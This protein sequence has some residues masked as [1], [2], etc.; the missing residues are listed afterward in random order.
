MKERTVAIVIRCLNEAQHIGKLLDGVMRQTITDVEIIVVDSGSTDTTLKIAA[1]Y[2]TKIVHLRPEEFT[3]G[4]ALNVGCREASAEFL[5]FASAHVHPVSDRWLEELLLPLEDERVAL[6]YGKQRGGPTTK[7]SEHRVFEQCFPGHSAARQDPSFC[8][9]AN[10]AIRRALWERYPYD[11]DLT[12]LEDLDWATRVRKSGFEVSYA[13]AAEVV[14]IHE[15]T[16]LQIFSRYCREAFA[17]AGIRPWE[18][19][20]PGDFLRSVL[21]VILDD[22]NNARNDRCLLRNMFSI[23]SFRVLQFWGTYRGF[24]R[25]ARLRSELTA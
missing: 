18:R 6:S 21:S 15:E 11:E 14:H 2:P 5:V 16:P 10:A 20:G 24:C 25:R 9:N 7:Y 17:L 3:Y 12:G 19:F 4:R 23:P 13:A 8:N 22:Y 1:E